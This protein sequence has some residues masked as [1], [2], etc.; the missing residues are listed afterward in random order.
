MRGSMS[1][2]TKANIE[3]AVKNESSMSQSLIHTT[4][5]VWHDS[6]VS[7]LN[8]NKSKS[9]SSGTT[10]VV[11]QTITGTTSYYDAKQGA[12]AGVQEATYY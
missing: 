12:K 9:G 11:N 4:N 6:Y 1:N 5:K 2:E 7:Q 3:Q 10:V 8:A